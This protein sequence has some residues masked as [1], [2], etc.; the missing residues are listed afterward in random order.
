MKKSG[1]LTKLLIVGAVAVIFGT[2]LLLA[3]CAKGATVTEAAN[4]VETYFVPKDTVIELNYSESAKEIPIDGTA[5]ESSVDYLNARVFEEYYGYDNSAGI[6]YKITDSGIRIW[7]ERT[8]EFGAKRVT[9][10]DQNCTFRLKIYFCEEKT[11]TNAQELM[12][13]N[14]PYTI[15]KLGGDID[16]SGVEWV[17]Y[18]LYG[19][20]D[21][22][23]YSVKNL[24]IEGKAGENKIGMFSTV[25]GGVQNVTLADASVTVNGCSEYVGILAGINKGKLKDIRVTGTLAAP[26]CDIVGAVAGAQ[27]GNS[28]DISVNAAVEGC[29]AVGG[30]F[31]NTVTT[32]IE[33]QSHL[34]FDGSVNGYEWVGGISGAVSDVHDQSNTSYDKVSINHATNKGKISGSY[35]VGGIVGYAVPDT[36]TTT[37]S[38]GKGGSSTSTHVDALDL[39]VN[40]SVNEG[41]IV[42]VDYVGGLA[43][44]MG[45]PEHTMT[46][47]TGICINNHGVKGVYYVGGI[48]GFAEGIWLD[49]LSNTVE[50]EGQAKVGGIAGESDGI[51]N[52]QNSG[53]ITATGMYYDSWGYAGGVAGSASEIEG[54]TNKGEVVSENGIAGGIAGF[55]STK[56]NSCTNEGAVTSPKRIG[57]I[58]GCIENTTAD[59]NT[60]KGAVTGTDFSIG[61][62]FGYT[63]ESTVSNAKNEGAVVGRTQ[64]GGVIGYMSG[65]SLATASST[66]TLV[67]ATENSVGGVIGYVTKEEKKST[68]TLSGLS[69]SS[70][71]SG[72][73][74]VG[75]SI[76]QIRCEMTVESLQ[77]TATAVQGNNF[78][79]GLIGKGDT[80]TVSNSMIINTTVSGKSFV[81]G[82]IGLGKGVSSGTFRGSI[83]IAE[84][85]EVTDVYVGGIGGKL[86]FASNCINY[87]KISVPNGSYVGGIAGILTPVNTSSP[88]LTANCTNKETVSGAKYVGGIA[89]RADIAYADTCVNEAA[90]T[91]TKR[92]AGIFGSA[93]E[94]KSVVNC[95]NKSEAMITAES[96]AAGIIAS[97]VS[98]SNVTG[99]RNDAAINCPSDVGSIVIGDNG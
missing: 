66:A 68:P 52:C 56:I 96:S 42:G 2:L 84:L 49:G 17:P 95:S 53:K 70:N 78:V 60:N 24:K 3:S 23:G 14:D 36:Y 94:V 71:V 19:C 28:S 4:L 86:D 22:N 92:V 90:I 88:N 34:S 35:Y 98:T 50:V 30:I 85:T 1:K 6:N 59:L 87:S 64:T 51:R 80:V 89:G 38:S 75:G 15:Y 67:S 55:V 77:C 41:E 5:Y 9:T 57:G 37:S 13:M 93:G 69:S 39:E 27:L 12:S 8:G 7:A 82:L 45:Y 99:C 21:G 48:V 91:G 40:S 65:G 43:G 61:G 44:A 26:D 25:Y 83:E 63:S 74:Y 81:G 97:S 16:M 18:D 72:A 47:F 33:K 20:F 46:G 11:V 79:G 10:D 73:D 32:R 76:G 31:G 58:A 29:R 62:V 54:C